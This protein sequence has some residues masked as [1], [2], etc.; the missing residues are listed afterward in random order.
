MQAHRPIELILRQIQRYRKGLRLTLALSLIGLGVCLA[1]SPTL[2]PLFAAA[3]GLS[4]V[5][6]LAVRVGEY[7]AP[8]ARPKA[9]FYG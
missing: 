8:L 3:A 7:V 6:V 9:H 1:W 5:G 2:V 4:G